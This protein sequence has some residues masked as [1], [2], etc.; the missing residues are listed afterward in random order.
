M[1]NRQGD[2][3][4]GSGKVRGGQWVG[5]TYLVHFTSPVI[6]SCNVVYMLYT[7]YVQCYSM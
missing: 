3:G 4:G 2:V 5:I 1:V 7:L 6:G